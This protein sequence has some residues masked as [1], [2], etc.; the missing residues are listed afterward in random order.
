MI[1]IAYAFSIITFL[2]SPGF[3]GIMENGASLQETEKFLNISNDDA[4]QL[5]SVTCF[6]EG[7]QTSGMNKICFYDCLGSA[8]AITISSIDLC[9]LSI[10][11]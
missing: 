11:Q 6:F 8:A 1:K 4:I 10:K 5:A 3:A 9:P 2:A 7:E